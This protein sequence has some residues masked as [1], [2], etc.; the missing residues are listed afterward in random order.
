MYVARAECEGRELCGTVS[1]HTFRPFASDRLFD[2]PQLSD[3]EVPLT[4]VQLRA[5]V[6]PDLA[7]IVL[8]GYRRPG[9]ER[10]AGLEPMLF[11]KRVRGGTGTEGTIVRPTGMPGS[12]CL[13]PELAIVIGKRLRSAS[14]DEAIEGIFGYTIFND[15]TMLEFLPLKPESKADYF[16]GKC[17]DTFASVGPWIRTDITPEDIDA[18]LAIEGRINGTVGIVGNTRNLKYS[19]GDMVSFVSRYTTLEPGDLISLGTPDIP[20]ALEPGDEVEIE[21]EGIGVLRNV[22][23]AEESL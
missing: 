21:I 9:T 6:S 11:P 23:A 14:H 20:P 16:R 4:D 13:E 2:H 1:S 17:A 5:P 3:V 12:I 22:V 10:R 7:W 18:G 15:V 8:G 19:V